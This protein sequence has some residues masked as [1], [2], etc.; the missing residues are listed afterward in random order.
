MPYESEQAMFEVA[1]Q[2]DFFKKL[3]EGKNRSK[4]VEPKGLFGIPDLLTVKAK[5]NGSKNITTASFEMKLK[6]WKR[7]LAQAFK[8]K[9]F[10][11]FSYVVMDHYYARPPLNNIHKF[12]KANIGLL[13]ID[14]GGKIYFHVKPKKEKPYCESFRERLYTLVQPLMVN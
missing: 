9:A 5:R 11:E 4:I 1:L 7:A 12:Q 13:S 10:S 6:N 14:L 3:I 2:T 8:Y